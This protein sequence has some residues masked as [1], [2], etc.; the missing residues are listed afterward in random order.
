MKKTA[1]VFMLC[2]PIAAFAQQPGGMNEEQMQQMMQQMQH[3]QTCMANID[4]AEMQAFQDRAKQMDEEMKA[5]CAAG[6]RDEAVAL[7]RE[8]GKESAANKAMQEM[9]KCGEGMQHML[10]NIVAK[11]DNSQNAKQRHICDAIN[12]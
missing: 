7:A 10:P 5:L 3:M 2:L 9:K 11:V 1:L 8:F 4:Q 6:K 12:D